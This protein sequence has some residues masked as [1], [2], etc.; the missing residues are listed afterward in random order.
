MEEQTRFPVEIA[1]KIVNMLHKV[2]NDNVNF[3]GEGGI[4][5]A[6]MQP[7]RLGKI[8][9]GAK[10]IMSGE[11]DEL[12]IT[13]EDAKKLKGTLPGYNGVVKY[14][15][16]RIGC[17]GLSGD[18]QQMRPLQQLATIIVM[19]EFGKYQTEANKKEVLEKVVGEIDEICASI[20][21]ISAGSE[22]VFNHSKQI[23]D[24]ANRAEKFIENINKVLKTV[25]DIADQ[26]TLLGFNA[27]IESARAGEYG[28]GFG[29]VAQEIRKLSTHS[30]QSLKDINLIMTEIKSSITDIAEKV[31]QNTVVAHAQ[32]GSIQTINNSIMGIQLETEKLR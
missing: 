8:H 17:I 2:T 10:R 6:T 14:K 18:P 26:T 20:Q 29:V 12:A 7:E 28:K 11:V 4:I 13:L 9:E 31:R 1:E 24:M 30:A 22:D 27:A 5:I 25:K 15:G 23:E 32:S 19:E 16:K 21:E 3:M